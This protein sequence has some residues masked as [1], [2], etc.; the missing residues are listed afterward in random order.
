MVGLIDSV[1]ATLA[2]TVIGGFIGLVGSLITL[3]VPRYLRTRGG[4]MVQTSRWELKLSENDPAVYIYKHSI[5][6]VN[7]ME[8]NTAALDIRLVLKGGDKHPLVCTP[9]EVFGHQRLDVLNLPSGVPVNR[10]VGG[11]I[12]ANVLQE[13]FGDPF[14]EASVGQVQL[15][16]SWSTGKAFEHNVIPEGATNKSSSLQNPWLGPW[17]SRLL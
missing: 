6:M 8:I 17:Y 7:H 14:E 5:S 12:A 3:F 9:T 10:D 16:G 15:K 11:E 2:G 13:H 4:I 1:T